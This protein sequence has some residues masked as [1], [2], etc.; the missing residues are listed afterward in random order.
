MK[1][2]ANRGPRRTTDVRRGLEGLLSLPPPGGNGLGCYDTIR[3]H[4][5]DASVVSVAIKCQAEVAGQPQS[6]SCFGRCSMSAASRRTRRRPT[7][8]QVV[9]LRSAQRQPFA[10]SR[11]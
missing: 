4:E 6:L 1:L 5:T 11:S 3:S 7:R 9:A 8:R 10:R 2:P